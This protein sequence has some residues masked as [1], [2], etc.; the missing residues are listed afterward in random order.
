M[1]SQVD[2]IDK[3]SNIQLKIESE[4]DIYFERLSMDGLDEMHQY[5]KDERLYECNLQ[6]HKK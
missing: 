5:S 3:F 4:S 2:L 1:M 6:R